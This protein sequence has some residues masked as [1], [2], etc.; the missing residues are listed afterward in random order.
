MY[1]ERKWALPWPHWR[2]FE[3]GSFFGKY[4][5]VSTFGE[6]HGPAVGATIEGIPAGV[7]VPT[8]R[9]QR[10]LDR[11]R[12]GTSAFVS[13]RKESDEVEIL[14]GIED[15][16]TLG[17][18]ISLLVRKRD[19]R[20]KDY[21]AIR[22]LVRPAHADYTYFKKYGI[23]PQPGGG[24]ASGRETVGRV[25]AG[26]V[27]KAFVEPRGILVCAYTVRIGEIQ[28][29]KVDPKYAERNPLR[30]ADPDVMDEMAGLVKRVSEDGD[31][32]GG[33]VE[34]LASGV[35]A[36][37]GSPVFDK[38]DALLGGAM[39]SIGGVKCVEFGGG[40]TLASMRGSQANDPITPGGF[41]TNYSGGLLGGISTGESIV[42][43]LAVKPT[44]SISAPQ[45]TVDI[46]GNERTIEVKG[47]HDPCLC[48]RI[49]P[50]AEAM[51]A[52]VLA[53]QMLERK[54]SSKGSDVT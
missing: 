35:P 5:S 33:V 31:S 54:A 20:S 29:G 28:V 21:R 52:L 30:C 13:A 27:A 41:L 10:E 49:G 16:K 34:V 38:L 22:E 51:A 8:E 37:L 44:P 3:M 9:I 19:A 7:S 42:I 23:S 24:R 39:L 14:S 53:D 47:R 25:A 32:V 46:H 18:P 2:G 1:P 6:S 36:G 11:R 17:S 15:G 48:P 50:V 40:F 45:H 26:A 43:R 12:P 4:V